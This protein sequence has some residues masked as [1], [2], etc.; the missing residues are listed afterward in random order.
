LWAQ[1]NLVVGM[2]Y[3]IG[4]AVESEVLADKALSKS[5]IYRVLSEQTSPSKSLYD[6]A[7]IEVDIPS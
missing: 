2:Q 3:L 4:T 1:R 6:V 7:K 5:A